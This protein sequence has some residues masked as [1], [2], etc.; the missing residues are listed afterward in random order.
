MSI[1]IELCGLNNN[2]I[3]PLF[4]CNSG[5][6]VSSTAPANNG[7]WG[8][9]PLKGVLCGVYRNEWLPIAVN[10]DGELEV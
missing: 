8:Q 10:A 4:V 6:V 7:Q 1:K 5:C 9:V 3:V 2:E